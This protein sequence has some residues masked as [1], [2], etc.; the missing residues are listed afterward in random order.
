MGTVVSGSD[1]GY[2][3]FVGQPVGHPTALRG[4]PDAIAA[5]CE[6][7]D[8]HGFA[9]VDLLAY[10]AEDAEP[11][12][13]VRAARARLR[14]RLIVAGS[15]ESHGQVSALRALGVDAFTIGSAVFAGRLDR[16][17]GLVSSQLRAVEHMLSEA[18]A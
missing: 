5:D 9:G 11:L 8:R 15:I 13:L 1:T 7:A 2:Y 14:G 3:P 12:E 17:A 16:R 4:T 10:R 6:A 18:A